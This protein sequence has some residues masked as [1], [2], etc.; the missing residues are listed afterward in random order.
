MTTT[1]YVLFDLDGLLI[2]SE[3][4]YTEV[5]NE[6]LLPY[7]KKFNWTLKANMMGKHERVACEYLV[8]ALQ[9]PLTVDEYIA[10]R[11]AK[12]NEAWPRLALRPGALELVTHLKAHN[13]PIAVATGS[14]KSSLMQ[15]CN[16]PVVRHLM[17]LFGE[18]CVTADDVGP[19]LGKP[20]PDT[21]LIAAQRLGA[22]IGYDVNGVSSPSKENLLA[23][24]SCLVFEDAV[25]GVQAGL[26]GN[27][28]VI[29][30]PEPELLDLYKD[31][32]SVKGV[33]Q[34]LTSLQDLKLSDFG[35]PDIK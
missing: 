17:S 15:K 14:R 33:Y 7:G 10:Q 9:I 4:V 23:R 16:A 32:D 29:W 31:D 12:Q 28:K 34:T 27:M 21:F 35:L 2:D 26:N 5:T 25:P 6:I 13:I 20:N 19:G 11:N 8:N 30:V 1:K 24:D 3:R 18:N 22:D